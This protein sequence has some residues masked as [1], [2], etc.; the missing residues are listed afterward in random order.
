MAFKI[1]DFNDIEKILEETCKKYILTRSQNE[2]FDQREFDDTKNFLYD[3]LKICTSVDDITKMLMDFIDL[4]EWL[5]NTESVHDKMKKIAENL[6]TEIFT[7]H[8]EDNSLNKE[9]LNLIGKENVMTDDEFNDLSKEFVEFVNEKKKKV[10]N[11]PW[12][13]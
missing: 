11:R 4:P 9:K 5:Y 12:K 6:I 8:V 3:Y 7:F 10:A 1:K 2:L 13:H